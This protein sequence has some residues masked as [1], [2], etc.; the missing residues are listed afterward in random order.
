MAKTLVISEKE[1]TR[2]PFL[3]GI[4]TRSL[5]DAGLSFEEAYQLASKIRGEL[6]KSAEITTE[7]LRKRVLAQLKSD[8][9]QKIVERYSAPA[10]SPATILVRDHHGETSPF[11]RERHRRFLE[12]TGLAA[13]KAVPI[14]TLIYERL[15]ADGENEIA[16]SRLAHLTYQCLSDEL[17]PRAARR[18]LVWSEFRASGRPLLLLIGGTIGSGKSTIATDI[19]HRLDIVRTQSTDMLR[20]VM[21]VMVPE[22][23]LPVLHTSS[24]KAWQALPFPNDKES[25]DRYLLAGY[26]RQTELLVVP[27]EAVLQRA[28]RE[29]V[30]L[31]L[32]GVHVQPSLAQHIPKDADAIVIYIMLAVLSP[33]ELRARLRGRTTHAPQRRAARYLKHFD[34]IWKL[35]SFLLS[36]ADQFDVPIIPNDDQPK[37][38][39]QV[40]AT[41]NQALSRQFK[42]SPEEVFGLDAAA[43]IS[44]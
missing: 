23:L 33:A 26:Q 7:Q 27:C 16:A 8:C 9:D 25:R 13:A 38:I 17:G 22:R 21:R 18:Y 29:R 20:E 43:T 2:V 15:L 4:L 31:I 41:I 24:F 28:L 11:S 34:A 32:E 35:Q 44:S 19:G 37:A 39:Q 10:R 14:T 5:Q 30:S 3:R 1:S 36:E 42:G 6:G 12:S 40:M